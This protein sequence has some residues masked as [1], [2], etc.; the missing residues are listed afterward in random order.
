MTLRG[1]FS[2]S[3]RRPIRKM[4]VPC[5]VRRYVPVRDVAICRGAVTGRV[6]KSA[7]LLLREAAVPSERLNLTVAVVRCRRMMC[8]RTERIYAILIR[9]QG[10]VCGV[11]R[12][13]LLEHR[14]FA[15]KLADACALL[16]VTQC[17]TRI[18]ESDSSSS[19]LSLVVAIVHVKREPGCPTLHCA[20]SQFERW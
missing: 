18:A 13:M 16:H 5:G 11:E 2:H 20:Q 3:C 17:K 9:W 8:M 10:V 14:P 19:R 12:N 1:R 4:Y 15:D 7:R 6:T